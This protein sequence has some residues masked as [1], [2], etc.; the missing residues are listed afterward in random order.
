[1]INC[2]NC[3]RKDLVKKA[4]PIQQVSSEGVGVTLEK[5]IMFKRTHEV[6]SKA[7][8]SKNRKTI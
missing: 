8:V 2:S 4:K 3:Y 6:E 1:L 5:G 7:A